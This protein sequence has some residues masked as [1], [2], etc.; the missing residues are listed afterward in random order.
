MNSEWVFLKLHSGNH[1]AA[2]LPSGDA[3]ARRWLGVYPLDPKKPGAKQLLR[4]LNLAP[5]DSAG[6]IY[7]LRTFELPIDV[8]ENGNSVSEEFL[9]NIEDSIAIGDQDLTAK[10]QAIGAKI[11]D[12]DLPFKCDYPI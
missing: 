2:A 4:R 3:R 9:V 11:Q 7:R 1:L 10:L 5:L 6:A 12:L 8:I